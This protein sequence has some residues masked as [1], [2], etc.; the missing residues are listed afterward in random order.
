M[1]IGN[2]PRSIVM[3]KCIITMQIIDQSVER[4]PDGTGSHSSGVLQS[5]FRLLW[6]IKNN[7][8]YKTSKENY[9]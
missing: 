9:P 2:T 5:I 4:K 7:N 6:L 8:A 1:T 3:A